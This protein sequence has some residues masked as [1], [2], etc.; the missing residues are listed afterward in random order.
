MKAIDLPKAVSRLGRPDP[1]LVRGRLE[2]TWEIVSRISLLL[3][4]APGES[5]Q[6]LADCRRSHPFLRWT[7][8]GLGQEPSVGDFRKKIEDIENHLLMMMSHLDGGH[9]Q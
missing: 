4:L 1:A 3:R 8:T 9:G 6:T 2:E 5:K 7:L